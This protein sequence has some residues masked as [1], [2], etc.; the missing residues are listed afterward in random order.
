MHVP[1]VHPYTAG[2]QCLVRVNV[3][4]QPQKDRNV[5]ISSMTGFASNSGQT[6]DSTWR[7]DVKS[8]NARGSNCP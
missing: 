4:V 7:W 2:F 8:V 1:V 5:P 3:L 6:G